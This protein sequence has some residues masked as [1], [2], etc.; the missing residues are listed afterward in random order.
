MLAE[1]LLK[2][3]SE[4]VSDISSETLISPTILVAAVL[5]RRARQS[6]IPTVSND[7]TF[8]TLRITNAFYLGSRLRFLVFG[9]AHVELQWK[10]DPADNSS[11]QVQMSWGDP[12]S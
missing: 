1:V 11:W 12:E 7:V 9:D 6:L 3:S 5:L 2:R 10:T 4:S 8:Q